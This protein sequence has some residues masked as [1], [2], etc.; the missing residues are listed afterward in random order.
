V[1]RDAEK[2]CA[3]AEQSIRPFL[4]ELEKQGALLH[5][6]KTVDPCFEVSAFLSAADAGPALMF[7]DVLGSPLK[8]AGNLFN[9]RERIAVALGLEVSENL[10]RRCRL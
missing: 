2:I 3:R 1:S 5:I 9:G 6:D 7:D 10:P 4:A 8:I